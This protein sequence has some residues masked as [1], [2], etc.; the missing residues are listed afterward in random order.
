[1]R[2][3]FRIGIVAAALGLVSAASGA[4]PKPT[5]TVAVSG[6]GAVTSL[7]AGIACRPRCVLHAKKGAKVTL[8]ADPNPGNEFSHWSAPCGTN[9]TCN[10]KMTGSRVVHAFFKTEPPAPK[11]EPPSPPPPSPKA[12]HYVGTYTDG[13]FLNF[14]VLG[15]AA[16]NFNFDFNG[17]CSDGG[18]S[19]DDG[20]G[21]NG[22]FTAASDGSFSGTASSTFSN[23]TVSVT[24]NG[25]ISAAG[26]ATGTLN[27]SIAFTNGPTCTSTGT[28]TAQDQS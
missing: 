23:S 3:L 19:Y 24:I 12:G 5:L 27:I 25:I 28:W 17:D 4:A 14:D 20:Y 1:V 9:F 7:P 11:P 8:T 13:T 2:T 15:S 26:A 16:S 22:P 6:K 21:V 10:V 18:T